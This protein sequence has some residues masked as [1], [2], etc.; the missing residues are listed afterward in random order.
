MQEHQVHPSC[1][2]FMNV[3][4]RNLCFVPV[5]AYY[6]NCSW[7]LYMN[8]SQRLQLFIVRFSLNY[9]LFA[10]TY[11]FLAL[12][13]LRSKIVSL[14]GFTTLLHFQSFPY[15]RWK[16]SRMRYHPMELG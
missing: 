3:I 2:Q 13:N 11:M 15:M 9:I 4:S 7:R 5:E 6:G 12:R 8:D 16:Q 14:W 10:M 1:D